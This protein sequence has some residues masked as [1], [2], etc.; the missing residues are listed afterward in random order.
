MYA[1]LT[2]NDRN[3]LIDIINN[4]SF[5][6]ESAEIISTLKSKL[7]TDIPGIKEKDPKIEKI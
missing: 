6:G 4:T 3:L 2:L 7:V 1:E 5:K